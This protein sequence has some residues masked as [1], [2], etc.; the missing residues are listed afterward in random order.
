MRRRAL[1]ALTRQE[2]KL[3]DDLETASGKK[4]SDC[5]NAES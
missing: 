5:N 1:Q 4:R 3:T 2:T